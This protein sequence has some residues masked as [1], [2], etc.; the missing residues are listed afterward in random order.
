MK[1]KT[2]I[3]I[4]IVAI[5]IIVAIILAISPNESNEP[6]QENFEVEQIIPEN[7]MEGILNEEVETQPIDLGE[8][9]E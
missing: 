1:N 5:V 7:E 4:T 6:S 8:L 3:I 2:A 9:I